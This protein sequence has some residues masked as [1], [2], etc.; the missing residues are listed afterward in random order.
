M[1]KRYLTAKKFRR[2]AAAAAAVVVFIA[3]LAPGAGA[4]YGDE[5]ITNVANVDDYTGTNI[6]G[7][8]ARQADNLM[9]YLMNRMYPL[10][11]VYMTTDI[12]SPTAMSTQFGGTW[13]RF[14]QG[15]IPVGADG[16]AGYTIGTLATPATGGS[17][18]ASS[19]YPISVTN[20]VP[21][22]TFGIT[23]GTAALSNAGSSSVGGMAYSATIN[24]TA[25]GTYGW[26]EN[27]YSYFDGSFGVTLLAHTHTYQFTYQV[28]DWTGTSNNNNTTRFRSSAAAGTNT[29]N[30]TVA[31]SYAG[32]GGSVSYIGDLYIPSG[33]IYSVTHA[34]QPAATYTPP[35]VAAY[36]SQALSHDIRVTASGTVTANDTTVQPYQV[37]YMYIRTG[38]AAY[39]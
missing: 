26:R 12:I 21:T 28:G 17:M 23:A 7:I 10:G 8:S 19:N 6:S 16:T 5:Y 34:T 27:Y 2:Y 1:M 39:R 18:D 31:V 4:A 13:E 14:G 20:I 35:V 33:T 22:G 32:A 30:W 25:T 11:S 36:V 9:I 29:G 37:C 24:G 38:L 3:L 15:R